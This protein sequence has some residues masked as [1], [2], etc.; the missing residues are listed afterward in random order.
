MKGFQASV[1]RV[2]VHT[3]V[4]RCNRPAAIFS[5]GDSIEMVG[6]PKVTPSK[7]ASAPPS[8]WPVIQMLASGYRYVRL[9]YKFFEPGQHPLHSFARSTYSSYRVE[10][11]ILH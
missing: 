5:P 2:R 7:E 3:G 4:G 9:L 11:A 10:K 6:A 8:E 1:S